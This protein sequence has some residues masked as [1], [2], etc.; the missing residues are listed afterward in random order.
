MLFQDTKLILNLLPNEVSISYITNNQK[1]FVKTV[2]L[3]YT[4]NNKT[5][6]LTFGLNETILLK[7]E[8]FFETFQILDSNFNVIVKEEIF[9]SFANYT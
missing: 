4:Q 9:E 6:E 1:Q 7:Q 3:I 2:P 8:E 5:D